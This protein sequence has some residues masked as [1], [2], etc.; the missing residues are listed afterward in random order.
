MK[1]FAEIDSYRFKDNLINN[2]KKEIEGNDKQYLL[3]IDEEEYISYLIAEYTIESLKVYFDSEVIEKPI[4]RKEIV[5]DR[6]Y[7]EK[8]ETD[9]YHFTVSYSFTGA[10][11][12]F[13][14]RPSSWVMRTQ[15]I[16]VNDYNNTVS[17]SFKLYKKDPNEFKNAKNEFQR[18]AF[19][20]LDNVNIEAQGWNNS[21]ESTVKS[22]FKQQK[23]KYLEEDDFFTA[24]NVKVDDQT[25]SVFST[26]TIKK[27]IVPQPRVPKNQEFASEPMMAKE[28]YEDILKVIYDFGKSMEKKP[29]T[30]KNKDEEGLRD[31]F[32]LLLETRYDNTT[33]SGE[34]FNR[35]GKTDIILKYAKDNSNLFV[36]E[37]K[38]WHG[39]SE[40]QKAIFQL[41]DRYLTW[42]DSKAALIIFVTNKEF[43]NVLNTIRQEAPKH[44]YF[45]KQ[46]SGRGESSF[47]YI[48]HLPQDQKKEVYF[49]IIVFHYD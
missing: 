20:N 9:V 10:A 47:S 32:L 30:Y 39:N 33:A 19:A 17:F 26:P 49:E 1:A 5:E 6:F 37:C 14:V 29:S 24:I 11:V 23:N 46:P 41:F 13:Q 38:F 18:G 27:K 3:G 40:F 16:N 34:T 8:Y 2:L 25:K 42:R 12:L 43:S 7:K 21:L 36:A 22:L 31:Q 4:T 28:M 35:A 48:F 44:P 15:E 45:V